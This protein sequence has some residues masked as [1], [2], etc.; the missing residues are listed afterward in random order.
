MSKKRIKPRGKVERHDEP[1]AVNIVEIP[2]DIFSIRTWHPDK[3]AE[4]PPEQVHFVLSLGDTEFAIRF[5]S[6]DTLGF[7][8]E[9]LIAYRKLVW[10]DA[11]P[12]N[13]DATLE[14][15]DASED[16]V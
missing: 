16:R 7:L 1:Q 2:L 13:P 6:P 8:I 11:E 9:E 15:E 14:K 10:G 4:L 12:I 5:K 3:A